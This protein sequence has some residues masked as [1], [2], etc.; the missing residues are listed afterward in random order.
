[1]EMK[2]TKEKEAIPDNGV[3][4]PISASQT[5]LPIDPLGPPNQ[6]SEQLANTA[7][8]VPE[9]ATS[10]A[11]K[12]DSEERLSESQPHKLGVKQPSYHSRSVIYPD[13]RVPEPYDQEPTGQDHKISHP[14]PGDDKGLSREEED[15]AEDL[16]SSNS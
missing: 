2:I 14:G 6:S 11:S 7:P 1:M 8:I 9:S 13:E 3:S 5:S 16:L 15:L 12:G 4:K 10:K